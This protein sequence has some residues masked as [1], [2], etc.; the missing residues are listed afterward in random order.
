MTHLHLYVQNLEV[1]IRDLQLF[2]YTLYGTKKVDNNSHGIL[3]CDIVEI[4]G[5]AT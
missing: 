3:V 4:K 5:T 2:V 1:R